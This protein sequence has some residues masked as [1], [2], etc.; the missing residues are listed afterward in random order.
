[1]LLTAY[2]LRS[3]YSITASMQTFTSSVAM[4]NPV[5]ITIHSHLLFLDYIYYLMDCFLKHNFMVDFLRTKAHT[6]STTK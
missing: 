1:M 2:L 5:I 4:A 3:A 6:E